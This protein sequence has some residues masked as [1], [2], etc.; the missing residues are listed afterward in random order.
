[1][2][3]HHCDI[4]WY[5]NIIANPEYFIILHSNSPIFAGISREGCITKAHSRA[6]FY[7]LHLLDSDYQSFPESDRRINHFELLRL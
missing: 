4:K 6:T 7:V 1:M 3:A 5:Y 2:H